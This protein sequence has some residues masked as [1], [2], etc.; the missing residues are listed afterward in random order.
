MA[1]LIPA[2]LSIVGGLLKKGSKN[3][4][5]NSIAASG[6]A[7][8]EQIQPFADAGVAANDTISNVLAGGSGADAAFKRFQEGTGFR[9]MMTEGSNAITG[10][11]AAKGLLN[12]GSTL[13]KLNQFGQ[14]RAQRSFGNFTGLAENQANRGANAAA[15]VAA[16]IENT[17]TQ[18]AQTRSAGDDG[19]QSGL[20]GAAEGV[21]NAFKSI[22]GG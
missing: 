16:N 15:R 13:K 10:N 11:A 18:V 1:S 14:D 9:A 3:K 20:G 17:G 7:A 5:A 12:S 19:F 4:E 21:V 8:N 2:G 6:A 22:R